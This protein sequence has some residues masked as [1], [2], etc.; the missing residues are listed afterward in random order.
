[1]D[2]RNL[3][4]KHITI[5]VVSGHTKA[6]IRPANQLHR[7]S[8]RYQM[9]QLATRTIQKPSLIAQVKLK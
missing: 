1:M 3:I 9:L 2:L 6:T 7:R 5:V 8:I 4:G